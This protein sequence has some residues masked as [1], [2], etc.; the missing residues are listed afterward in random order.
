MDKLLIYIFG[1]YLL[2]VIVGKLIN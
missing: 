2:F 1:V